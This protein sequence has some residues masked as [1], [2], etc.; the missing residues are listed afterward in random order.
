MAAS[1]PISDTTL[2]QY[3][4]GERTYA[5]LVGFTAEQAHTVADHGLTF[6]AAAHFDA[7]IVIFEGLLAYNPRDAF[8]HAVRG[9]IFETQGDDRSALAHY[10]A[11]LELEPT[12]V[13]PRLARAELLLR[14]GHHDLAREDLATA[15]P[16]ASHG[17]ESTR[18]AAIRA[19][20]APAVLPPA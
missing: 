7:A 15:A 3:L 10:S 11:A 9:A 5:E 1:E 17:D 8:A 2:M 4:F 20:L 13:P 19:R 16:H 6:L 14:L 18:L 12:M